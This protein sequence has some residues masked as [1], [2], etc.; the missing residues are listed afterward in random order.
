L[1]EFYSNNFIALGRQKP[2]PNSLVKR[3]LLT[4]K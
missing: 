4:I 2:W 3:L 1:Y